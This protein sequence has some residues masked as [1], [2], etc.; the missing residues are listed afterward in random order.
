LN[1]TRKHEAQWFLSLLRPS[2]RSH[3]LSI[4][5]TVLGSSMFLLDP[6]LIKWLIDRVLPRKDLHLLLISAAGFLGIYAGR[7]A[8]T[9]LARL[10]S[11]RAVQDLAVRMR[12]NILE[13]LNQLA[14]DYHDTA[15]PGNTLY[16][17]EQ[18]VDQVSEI[19]SGLVPTVLQAVF[20]ALFVTIT[21]CILNW[22][23]AL[24]L[25]PLVPL[26]FFSKR[27]FG[28]RLRLASDSAQRAASQ[29]TEFL[30]EHVCSIIQIQLLHQEDAQTERFLHRA[31]EKR[32][33]ANH[34]TAIEMLFASCYMGLI[35][36]GT[37]G[38]VCYGGYQV[39]VGSL[40]IGGLVAFYSYLGR[41]FDPVN[42]AVDIYSRLNRLRSSIRRILEI[43]DRPSTVINQPNCVP[44]APSV[45]ADITISEVCFSYKPDAP[46][47]LERINLRVHSGDKIAL[48]GASG[49]GKSTITKLVARLYDV[50]Q[51]KI[52]LDGLD[53]RTIELNSLRTGIC[54]LTQETV[55]F[56]RSLKENLLLANPQATDE[57]LVRAIQ[58]AELE[59]LLQRLPDGWNTHLGPR[60][61][62]LSGGERQRIALARAVLQTPSLLILDESTSALDAPTE[63]RIFASLRR[64]FSRQTMILI[65]HRVAALSWVN[66]IIV[67]DHGRIVEDGTHDY[68]LQRGGIYRALYNSP[69]TSDTVL[70]TKPSDSHESLSHKPAIATD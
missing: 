23:L 63:Q 16:A 27:H 43:V 52:C 53:L 9:T 31:I 68:L 55:L 70:T 48:V 12:L 30:Q 65:S 11:F 17:L 42:V 56:D 46:R 15:A 69:L 3:V 57:E 44:L 39:F 33:A 24:V 59:T 45:K 4:A 8:L 10:I 58:M 36:L 2:L 51:G 41:L 66:R 50:N 1:S 47:V 28:S 5:L 40:T 34:R 18:D 14:A 7:V 62:A 13:R 26:F 35:A 19:G 49:S 67:L 64:H 21:V 25:V 20:N 29:E 60:G 22:R 6:L 61:N 32:D 37:V 54:Y 38:I